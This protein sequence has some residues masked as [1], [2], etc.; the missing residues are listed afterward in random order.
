M[1]P[2]P[3]ERTVL[4]MLVFGAILSFFISCISSR[5]ANRPHGKNA[6][7]SIFSS[8]PS[9]SSPTF[10]LLFSKFYLTKYLNHD[11]ISHERT[12]VLPFSLWRDVPPLGAHGV[13]NASFWRHFL[14]FYFMYFFTVRKSSSWKKCARFH[15]LF[16]PFDFFPI[17]S[18]PFFKILL[19]KIPK[20]W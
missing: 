12:V 3:A 18:P 7:G 2:P 5:C 4:T 6:H 8:A 20:S 15:F 13:D 11:R 16:G 14:F 17:F 19:D 10:H 9:T 1:C